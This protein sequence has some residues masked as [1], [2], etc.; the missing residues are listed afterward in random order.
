M[1]SENSLKNLNPI[2]PGSRSK[3]EAKRIAAKGGRAS[4]EARKKNTDLKR[5]MKMIMEM[6]AS[7]RVGAMLAKMGYSDDER[8]NANA[9]AATLYSKAIMGD[10]KALEMFFNYFFQASE[11]ERKTKESLAR[12]D[13]LK[14]KGISAVNSADDDDGGVVIYLPEIETEKEEETEAE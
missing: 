8:T 1:V 2:N 13:A 7:G 14:Q 9:M 10:I 6:P 3:E 4:A 12:I 11:D 5:A